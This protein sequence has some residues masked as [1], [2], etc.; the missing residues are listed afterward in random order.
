LGTYNLPADYGLTLNAMAVLSLDGKLDQSFSGDG[1]RMFWFL[2][3]EN[4]LEVAP[5]FSDF[6]VDNK[7]DIVLVGE[8]RKRL[9]LHK[10]R[11][12]GDHVVSF[13]NTQARDRG[14]VFH[15][16]FGSALNRNV[17]NISTPSIDIDQTSNKIYLG[18]SVTQ[19]L[20]Q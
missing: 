16:N 12:T 13:G 15:S 20:N 18:F 17:K 11:A 5:I 9:A 1:K 7:G 10:V 2:P 4:Q 3:D 8:H 14:L 6:A 19:V